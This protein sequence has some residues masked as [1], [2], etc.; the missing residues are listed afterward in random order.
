VNAAGGA[1]RAVRVS[2][3]D[4]GVVAV[5]GVGG[6]STTVTLPAGSTVLPVGLSASGIA[7]AAVI[8]FELDGVRT[9]MVVVV[10]DVPASQVPAVTSPVIG[11][12]VQ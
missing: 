10:G 4:A 9:Q 8:T 1:D 7:G 3:S 5:G 12:R 2:T 6:A 11:V